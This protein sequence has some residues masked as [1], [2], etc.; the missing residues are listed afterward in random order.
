[1]SN[2]D[3]EAE[4]GKHSEFLNKMYELAK[5]SPRE[6][7]ISELHKELDLDIMQTQEI[8]ISLSEEGLITISAGEYI[9]LTNKGIQE[10]EKERGP[11]QQWSWWQR[12]FG[13]GRT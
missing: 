9:R 6:V 1:M 10:V 13:K 3:A 8:G 7:D 4:K 11:R 2:L 12:L 5:G